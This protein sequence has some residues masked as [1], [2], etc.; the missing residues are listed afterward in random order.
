MSPRPPSIDTILVEAVEIADPA[1]R[2]AFVEK[3]CAG[4]AALM[5]R[6]E[7]LV[8]DHFRAG[9]FLER[10]AADLLATGNLTTAGSAAADSPVPIEGPAAV[11]GAYRLLEQIGE[12]G[13]G[14]VFVAE[15]QYPVRR[16]VALKVVKPG[17]DSRQV[18][19]RFEAERQALAMMDHANIAKI[20][21]GGTTPEGRPY[22]VMELVKGTPITD[23]CD[24][25]HLSTRQ[26]LGLFLDVCH[27]VQHAHQKGVIHRDLKPSN[28]L[29]EIHDVRPVVKVIDFGI[30]KATGQQLTDKTV[31][32]AL[33]QMVGTPMYMSPEQA[34]L[35]SLDVDTRSDV[36]SL[37]VLL[38]ELLTGTTPFDSETLK[39]GGYDEM[40]RIIREEEP[41]R[42]S[43]RVSTAEAKALST[44]SGKWR[45]DERRL[46]QELQGE[47]DW[48]VMKALEKD[49]QRRY[50]SAGAFA[51]DV[52][53]Y[54]DDEPVAACPPSTAYRLR[55]YVRRNKTALTTALVVSTA[56]L[57]GTVLSLWQALEATNARKLAD[58]RLTLADERLVLADER[59]E[60]EKLARGEAD[61]QRERASANLKQAL[62]ALERAREEQRKSDRLAYAHSV[63]LSWDSWRSGRAEQAREW[64]EAARPKDEREDLREFAWRHLWSLTHQEELTLIG[65][66]DEVF[67]VALSP[68][69]SLVASGSK[70]HTV[71]I[72]N[73]ATGEPL[74]TLRGHDDEVNGVA[75][76]PDG[77][78]LASASEEGRLCV[79]DTVTWRL[80]HHEID[81]ERTALFGIAFSPDG[82]LMAV[83]DQRGR[84]RLWN[85]A[86]WREFAPLTGHS[87]R[88]SCV[89]FSPDGQTIVSGSEDRTLRL[90]DVKT[91]QERAQLSPHDSTVSGVAFSRDGTMLANSSSQRPMVAVRALSRSLELGEDVDLPPYS[92]WVEAVAF[93]ANDR[94]LAV[95]CK[96]G[97]LELL[98][99]TGWR[100]D[101][102]GGRRVADGGLRVERRLNSHV[103]RVWGLAVSSDG[104]RLASAGADRTVRL[105]NVTASPPEATYE[106]PNV[107]DLA[108]SRDGKLLALAGVDLRL[109]DAA[110]GELK[111]AIG[112]EY[113]VSGDFDG[114][115]RSDSGSFRDGTWQIALAEGT[116]YRHSF[117]RLGDLPVVGDWDAD[118]RTDLGI[119][120]DE[121]WQLEAKN[122]QVTTIRGSGGGDG[123]PLSPLVAGLYYQTKA[124]MKEIIQSI[125]L[126]PGQDLAA[127]SRH[128]SPRITLYDLRTGDRAGIVEADSAVTAVEF[129]PAGALLATADDQGGIILWDIVERR[130]QLAWTVASDRADDNA[131]FAIDFSPDGRTLATTRRSRRGRVELW[132]TNRGTLTATL[133]TQSGDD[134][135]ALA[136]SHDGRWLAATG[137]HKVVV[138]DVV[139]AQVKT[140]LALSSEG[141][142]VS[143]SADGQ[144]IATDNGEGIV[145]VWDLRTSQQ[146][147]TFD[148]LPQHIS[149]LRFSPVGWRLAVVGPLD[150]K[151]SE[152]HILSGLDSLKPADELP[153]GR[154][155]R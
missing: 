142:H 34:G 120:R 153:Q 83:G 119:Y 118:G 50:E 108:F 87:D 72:W 88:A 137:F 133:E 122:G 57:A 69:G 56:L 103:G 24:R 27:A 93:C 32:T 73:A 42:P 116:T 147:V 45:I 22:F 48:I 49:R 127:T 3:C 76:S 40:R 124:A 4:D 12:G 154:A 1:K 110:T 2:R 105:W 82:E 99:M 78:A 20:Y 139:T 97:T 90:W 123:A 134:G 130:R 67:C 18:V 52:Q 31:Y 111:W 46:T 55:K 79:W 95:A 89:A 91:R 155:G 33:A 92:S 68:D 131:V 138:W 145:S 143:F 85:T 117:G 80:V 114:D 53:R 51:A 25:H 10:P 132:E 100:D 84:V 15:Q 148:S 14:L 13:M 77:A 129:S 62:R 109:T 144:T 7:R 71:R 101:S 23:Y 19:A 152:V 66:D 136:F 30:A 74:R 65:H 81:R 86:D 59:L 150:L 16:R 64:L 36:Y 43:T 44:I 41:P 151:S 60:N 35:S 5:R 94:L 126:S 26:R 102:A 39:Q 75:F 37:G 70:D 140:T 104:G 6:V 9:S 21:D 128:H 28:V 58:E 121:T 112:L 47:L 106:T 135:H 11:I 113:G 61:E 29:V 17:M 54:L 107:N 96:N 63:R 141:R 149:A 98:T 115:G 146:L 8:A 38:Y 125:S